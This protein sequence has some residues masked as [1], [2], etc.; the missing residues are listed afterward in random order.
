[1]NEQAIQKKII[2]HLEANGFV[3]VKIITA[4][5]AGIPDIIACSPEGQSWAVEVKQEKGRL[6]KLQ[7]VWLDRFKRNNAVAFCCYGWQDYLRQFSQ[8]QAGYHP[9]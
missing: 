1:M 6:S 2:T 3:V 4:N 8:A 7:Q 5:R 9:L